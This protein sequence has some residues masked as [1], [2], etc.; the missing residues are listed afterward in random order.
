LQKERGITLFLTTHYMEEAE[1]CHRIG[2]MSQG[3]LIALDTPEALKQG[4]GHD[5]VTIG[6][7]DPDAAAERIAKTYGVAV[8]R[9][10]DQLAFQVQDGAA[11]LPR[12]IAQNGLAIR[13]VAVRR[14]T[15]EDVFLALTG[16]AI[17]EDS[18]DH[19]AAIKASTRR[20][21]RR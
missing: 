21:R 20:G 11:F 6:V 9:D 1:H 18:P 12:L 3:R 4:V 13:R 17:R 15:L 8:R 19:F 14:P 5:T 2:I 10:G 7:D 16:T